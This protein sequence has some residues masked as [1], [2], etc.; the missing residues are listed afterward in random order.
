M[1]SKV[2]T[3]VTGNA[4]KLEEVQAILGNKYPVVAKDIDLPEIQG[5]ADEICIAKCLEAVKHVKGPVFIE[6]VSLCFNG[7]QGLPGKE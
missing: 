7:L 4:K 2:I 3:F 1:G 6:D 5:E